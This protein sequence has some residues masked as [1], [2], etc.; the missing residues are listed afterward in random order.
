MYQDMFGTTQLHELQLR[1]TNFT[2]EQFSLRVGEGDD[3]VWLAD[4]LQFHENEILVGLA[5]YTLGTMF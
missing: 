2:T 1:F 5:P 4:Q 3:C